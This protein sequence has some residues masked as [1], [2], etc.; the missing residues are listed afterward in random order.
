MMMQV[1][2]S[3]RSFYTPALIKAQAPQ[4]RDGVN[5]S[6]PVSTLLGATFL[7]GLLSTAAHAGEIVTRYRDCHADNPIVLTNV[8]RITEATHDVITGVEAGGDRFNVGCKK[9]VDAR[10]IFVFVDEHGNALPLPSTHQTLA[11]SPA[12][13]T[14]KPRKTTLAQRINRLC[15]T[16]EVVHVTPPAGR[17][18]IDLGQP[19]SRQ[20]NGQVIDYPFIIAPQG[21]VVYPCPDGDRNVINTGQQ[22]TGFPTGGLNL[23]Y[24]QIPTQNIPY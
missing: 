6:K 10:T 21:S 5:F 12:S 4:Q 19:S 2:S 13:P 18:P 7:T 11:P 24:R 17:G 8:H 22:L 15:N 23:E 1:S 3:Q 20:F 9:S 16:D 14:H